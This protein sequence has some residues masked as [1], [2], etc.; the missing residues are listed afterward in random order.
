MCKL[1]R[2]VRLQPNVQFCISCR[3]EPMDRLQHRLEAVEGALD[4]LI[5][6]IDARLTATGNNV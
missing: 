6:D 3:C 2:Q 1:C 5:A 4:L